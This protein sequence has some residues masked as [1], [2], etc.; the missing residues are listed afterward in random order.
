MDLS[1]MEVHRRAGVGGGNS[2]V[3]GGRGQQQQHQQ[4]Q[5]IALQELFSDAHK[6]PFHGRRISAVAGGALK[7]VNF[8]LNLEGGM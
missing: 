8:S 7:G 5:T 3:K 6:A 4:Q 1:S 2:G